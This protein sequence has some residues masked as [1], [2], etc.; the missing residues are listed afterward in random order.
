MPRKAQL[1]AERQIA[2]R[3]GNAREQAREAHTE[4]NM[5]VIAF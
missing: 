4:L 2:R 5:V 1:S 3:E